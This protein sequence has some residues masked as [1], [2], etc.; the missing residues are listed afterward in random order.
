MNGTMAAESDDK[1]RPAPASRGTDS[2]TPS[3]RAKPSRLTRPPR[4]V[5]V[6]EDDRQ[7]GASQ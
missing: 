1:P 6:D 5:P 7:N 2:G 4:M 3:K